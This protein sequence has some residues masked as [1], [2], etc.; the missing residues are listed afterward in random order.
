[1]SAGDSVVRVPVLSTRHSECRGAVLAVGCMSGP[2]PR[3][4]PGERELEA[5]IRLDMGVLKT[6]CTDNNWVSHRSQPGGGNYGCHQM[7]IATFCIYHG[8]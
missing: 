8:L 1:M 6:E 7:L 3:A 2:W 4:P 5:R